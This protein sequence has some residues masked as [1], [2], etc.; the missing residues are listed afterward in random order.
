MIPQV[1]TQALDQ[2]TYP[3]YAKMQDTPERIEET[4][5]NTLSMI[6][7][8]SLPAISLLFLVSDPLIPMLF[9]TKWASSL[10]IARIMCIFSAASCVGG[11]IFASIIYASGKPKWTTVM[12]VFRI[13]TLPA[14]I[15]TSSRWGVLGVTWGFSIWGIIGRIF[16]QYILHRE[17]GYSIKRYFQIAAAPVAMNVATTALIILLANAYWPTPPTNVRWTLRCLWVLSVSILWIGLYSGLW[18]VLMK[19]NFIKTTTLLKSAISAK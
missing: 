8:I 18:V 11:G 19:E 4:Y 3:I 13:L 7:M 15:I 17:F 16:N 14:F 12:N 6:S 2:V 9:G 1:I 10:P 5:W